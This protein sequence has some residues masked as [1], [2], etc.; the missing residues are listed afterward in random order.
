MVMTGHGLYYAPWPSS[1]TTIMPNARKASRLFLFFLT[2]LILVFSWWLARELVMGAIANKNQALLLMAEKQQPWFSWTLQRPRDIVGPYAAHWQAE[3]NGLLN[4]TSE[5]VISLPMDGQVLSAKVFSRLSIRYSAAEPWR[6]RVHFQPGAQAP[7]YYSSD[8][9]L[10]PGDHHTLNVDLNTL[11]W[12]VLPPTANRF[13]NEKRL[14]DSRWG[15]Q[16]GQVHSILLYFYPENANKKEHGGNQPRLVVQSVSFPWPH[17]TSGRTD[18]KHVQSLDTQ[19]SVIIRRVPTTCYSGLPD[20][21]TPKPASSSHV[22]TVYMLN[23]HCFLPETMLWLE[24]RVQA[25]PNRLLV[26][27][28]TASPLFQPGYIL[29]LTLFALVTVMVFLLCRQYQKSTSGTTRAWRCGL[30]FPLL[31]GTYLLT[32]RFD[33]LDILPHTIILAI[34]TAVFLWLLGWTLAHDFR[35]LKAHRSKVGPTI[36]IILSSSA[37]TLLLLT[38]SGQPFAAPDFGMYLTWAIFQQIVIGPVL[39]QNFH[40]GCH[41]S[42]SE[43]A[44]LTGL[45]FALLHFPNPMLML[46]T[47]IAGAIWAG[48]WLKY[49][50]LLPLAI[51]HALLALAFFSFTGQWWLASGR[52]GAAF[53]NF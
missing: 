9:P 14:Q 33:R 36:G 42:T 32:G 19:T 16:V 48:L 49:Q 34:T 26:L 21:D 27:E 40:Q 35:Q 17:A 12:H 8:I 13:A 51:S 2:S 43:S 41:L 52:V 6:M 50:L 39:A 10:S 45:V 28:T 53:L 24:K 23:K 47:A 4:T 30:I 37:I 25:Q 5:P 20:D 11:K 3:N 38:I 15:G 29:V 7:E 31:A 46:V 18:Q 44:A 22:I 1:L